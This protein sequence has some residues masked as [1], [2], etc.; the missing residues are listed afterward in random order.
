MSLPKCL[1]FRQRQKRFYSG[2]DR[3]YIALFGSMIQIKLD[4]ANT[5]HRDGAF[6][7]HL[8]EAGLICSSWTVLVLTE[9]INNCI[10]I[11]CQCGDQPLTIHGCDLHQKGGQ[12]K[13]RYVIIPFQDAANIED[14]GYPVCDI[15]YIVDLFCYWWQGIQPGGNPT[16]C[17]GQSKL[18]WFQ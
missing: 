7:V 6:F 18:C 14:F 17:K 12:Q 4:A 5:I 13:K 8:D 3:I 16:F 15:G 9:W 10:F 11:P 2:Y 1:V